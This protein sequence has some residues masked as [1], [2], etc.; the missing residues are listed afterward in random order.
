MELNTGASLSLINETMFKKLF[1]SGQRPNPTNVRLRTYTG[2]EVQVIGSVDIEVDYE[3]Q[4]STLLVVKGNGP[5]LFGRNWMKTIRLN[6]KQINTVIARHPHSL[7]AVL[8]RHPAVFSEKLGLL[9]S[10]KARI[11]VVWS[12]PLR[13]ERN[14]LEQCVYQT[15]S[16]VQ[17]Y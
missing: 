5:N 8:Q 13:M 7:E 9:R 14:G 6:W 1:T 15:R 16:A 4:T 3:S 2:D 12:P 11:L 10:T 17:E